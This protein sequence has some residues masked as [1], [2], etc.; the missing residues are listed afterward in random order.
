M[1]K[2]LILTLCLSWLVAFALGDGVLAQNTQE[3]TQPK[4]PLEQL[5]NRDGTLDLKS[6]FRGSLGPA[7]WQMTT[8]P[9]GEPRFVATNA[10]QKND[11]DTQLMAV[12]GDENWADRFALP[13]LNGSL[14]AIAVSGSEVYAGGSF[15]TAG[16]VA[17]NQIAKRSEERRGGKESRSRW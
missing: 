4:V 3:L 15:T 2:H 8:G 12:P 14:N 7:G 13:G 10:E 1:R 11:G 6:G 17:A 5:L 9:N 16:G